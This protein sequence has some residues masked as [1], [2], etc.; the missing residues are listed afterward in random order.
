MSETRFVL[1]LTS[2]SDGLGF[3]ERQDTTPVYVLT[4]ALDLFP[5]LESLFRV[6]RG[7]PILFESSP[8]VNLTQNSLPISRRYIFPPC[9]VLLPRWSRFRVS[10]DPGDPLTVRQRT[11]YVLTCID[12]PPVYHSL[13]REEET[14]SL[15][16]SSSHSTSHELSSGNA[17]TTT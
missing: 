15:S 13:T 11:L 10:G 2:F 6:S 7:F 14:Y 4:G 5:Y 8:T 1:C 3:L 17:L 9:K 12:S 16:G